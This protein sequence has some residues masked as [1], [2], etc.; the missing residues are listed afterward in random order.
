MA[1]CDV[2]VAQIV[3]DQRRI[4]E[5][6]GVDDIQRCPADEKFQN[7][8]EQH[9]NDALFVLQTFFGIRPTGGKKRDKKH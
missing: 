3:I 8:H 4:E 6:D 2:R 7:H 9:L 1:E 5:C